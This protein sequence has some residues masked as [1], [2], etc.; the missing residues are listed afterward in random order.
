MNEIE[1]QNIENEINIYK[2]LLTNTDY[3]TLKYAD[4]SLSAEEYEQTKQE[5]QSWRARINE[6]EVQLAQSG[7][8][9]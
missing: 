5:R 3:R 1:R 6:L 2:Q 8:Q 4:G 9:E 7:P